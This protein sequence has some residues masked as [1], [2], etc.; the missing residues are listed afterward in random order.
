M[1]FKSPMGW[2]AAVGPL[3]V[4]DD[5]SRYLVVLQAVGSPR[6]E[7]VREQIESAF[8]R[9]G[10]PQAMLMDH[11]TPWWSWSG[12]GAAVTGLALWLMK[13]GIRLHWSGIGHPQ[14]QGKVERFHGS[15]Q[16]ALEKR[17]LCG[18]PPQAWLD[19]YRWEHNHLRPHEALGMQTPASRW[20]PS[21][22]PYDPQP[23]RWEYAPGAW[24]LKVDCQGKLDI[25]GKKWMI[26]RALS[27]EWVQILRVEHRLQ[28]Y[29]CNTL[30][31][32]L[33]PAIHRS[34]IVERWIATELSQPKL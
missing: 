27:G 6:A 20:R 19:D 31:R 29:Y 32:E 15:L 7:V 30:I 21:A 16:R 4:L 11:G 13:Q 22:R 10:V 9:C 34:T 1:D 14:T 12:P 3:S 23:L 26:S 8:G 17:G 5:H 28:V 24:V 33:E 18:Q 25:A 2:Q